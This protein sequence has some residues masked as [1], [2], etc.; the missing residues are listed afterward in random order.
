MK[1][2]KDIPWVRTGKTIGSGG[3]STVQEVEPKEP[4]DFEMG[5]YA[6][7]ILRNSKSAQAMARF[8][9]EI[10]AIKSLD[11]SRIVQI[12]DNSREGADFVYY[13][14]PNYDADPLDKIA[15][16]AS[17]PFK[18][19]AHKCLE[20]IAD[21]AEALQKAHEQKIVHRDLKPGNILV[22]RETGNPIIIDFGCCQIEGSEAITLTDEGVGSRNYMAP[23]CESGA[24]GEPGLSADI[25]SL[26]KILWSLAT[27]SPAF[28]RE[29][30]AFK[31]KNLSIML[32][33]DSDCWHLTRILQ[34][35]VRER[36]AARFHRA[37]ELADKARSLAR[38]IVGRYPPI[39]TVGDQCP[40]C[41]EP[42][43]IMEN[44]TTRLHMV[45][46]NPNPR[47]VSPLECHRCGYL[48]VWNS[49][50]LRKAQKDLSDSS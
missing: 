11:D 19:D 20:F 44:P 13:V 45:F 1:F 5:S 32:P 41:G 50:I 30:P 16:G 14:M 23:E 49:D 7:K 35:T 2:P 12:I 26:G 21:C 15:F 31:N 34:K 48:Y 29:E 28:A 38:D 10:Q 37:E 39:E 40:A 33:D 9:R 42:R 25:Y 46:G 4:S 43:N 36:P 3:Q 8:Q 18:A 24:G 47:G 22:D 6:L 17:S 27:G